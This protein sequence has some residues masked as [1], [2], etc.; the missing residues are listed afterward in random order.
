MFTRVRG[1]L[2]MNFCAKKAPRSSRLVLGY[3]EPR[4]AWVQNGV[5]QVKE[6]M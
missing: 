4:P 2:G 5:Y 1:I 6:K 3:L